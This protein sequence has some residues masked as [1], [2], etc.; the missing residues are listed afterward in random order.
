[1]YNSYLKSNRI[2]SGVRNYGQVTQLLVAVLLDKKGLPV[3]T[4][5]RR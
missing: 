4:D 2:A 3:P 5:T 1:M